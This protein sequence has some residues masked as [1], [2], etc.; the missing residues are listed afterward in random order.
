M[1]TFYIDQPIIATTFS[2][3]NR[4]GHIVAT[5]GQSYAYSGKH[6]VLPADTYRI[7][8]TTGKHAA[9]INVRANRL[10][11]RKI[12]LDMTRLFARVGSEVVA[13]VFHCTAESNYLYAVRFAGNDALAEFD[14]IG[15][16]IDAVD[17]RFVTET[18]MY[19]KL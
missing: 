5:P 19:S 6:R 13:W 12:I 7:R 15:D 8:Y 16:A 14:S 17:Q 2:G 11:H 1:S 18:V 10:Q 3:I 9:Y 4:P